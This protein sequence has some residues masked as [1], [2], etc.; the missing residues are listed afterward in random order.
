M[1]KS[2]RHAFEIAHELEIERNSI[3][4]HQ[5]IERA[6]T[7]ELVAAL[8][9]EQL[10]EAG[11]YKMSAVVTLKVDDMKIALP[12]CI[13]HGY[14]KPDTTQVKEVLRHQFEAPEKY[15]FTAVRSERIIPKNSR[16]EEE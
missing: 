14:V 4:E 11:N 6:L 10:R 16:E 2:K 8:H 5:T 9:T 12:W 7:A 15:G 1:N 3:K 13:E